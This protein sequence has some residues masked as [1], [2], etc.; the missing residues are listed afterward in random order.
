MLPASATTRCP[1]SSSMST[2]IIRIRASSSTKNMDMPC[3][4][5]LTGSS[6]VKQL[7][8]GGHKLRQSKWLFQ[9][10]AVGH[11]ARGPFICDGTCHVDDWKRGVGL[12]GLLCDFPAVHA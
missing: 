3:I 1:S 4:L 2:I 12:S 11:A 7:R 5:T 6:G 10:Y 9:Q 8:N